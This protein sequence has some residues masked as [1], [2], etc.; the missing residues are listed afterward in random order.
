VG[1]VTAYPVAGKRKSY[2]ICQAFLQG[3]GGGKISTTL[4]PGPAVFYGVNESNVEI[5]R[6]VVRTDEDWFYVDNSYFDAVRQKQFRI[7]KNALQHNGLGSSDGTRFRALGVQIKPWKQGQHILVVEQ[8]A[9]FM[10]TVIGSTVNW[11]VQIV[12]ALGRLTR[13]P[14][15]VR[16][17]TGDKGKAA[18]SLE[19][20][21]VDA[22]AL[23]TWSSAAATTAVLAGVPIVT[24]GQCAAETMAG[25]LMKIESL[26]RLE[27]E[28]W[29]G[30]L[31]DNQWGLAEIRSGLAWRS[32]NGKA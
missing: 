19:D 31:A 10:R 1:S 5:W 9:S 4:Q 24:M 7:T 20:D 8:S 16:H 15:R 18:R 14:I 17:W 3:C 21:L 30:V 28:E 11:T 6:A 26:P 22:H 29:A 12:D 27:R 13:R 23:V 25:S 32:L 2:E